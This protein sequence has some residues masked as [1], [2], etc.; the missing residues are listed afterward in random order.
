MLEFKPHLDQTM[1]RMEAFWEH[2]VLDRPVAQFTVDKPAGERVPLP[3]ANHATSAERWLDV[4]YQSRL[5][6]AELSNRL[7]PGDSLPV[8]FPNL[9]PEILAAFYGC[10]LHFGDYGTSWTEPINDGTGIEEITL[11]W[12][13]PYFNKLVELTDAML[14][15]G[16]GKYIVGM[17]DWHPG[18]D[19]VAAL[20]NPQ[21][22]ASDLIENP[23]KV[24][25]LLKHLQPDYFKVYNYWYEKLSVSGQPITSW[26]NLASYSKYYIPS[27]DFAAMI[28]L[29]MFQ[30]F[31]LEGIIAECRFL[32]RSIYHLDGPGALRHL[33]SILTIRELD[34]LQW[35]PGAGRE[36]YSQWIPIYQKIQ[37]AG[38]SIIVYCKVDDLNL[39]METLSPCGL[40]LSIEDITD[41]ETGENILSNLEKWTQNQGWEGKS[42]KSGY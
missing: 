33:D 4:D 8:A 26:L 31:F 10:P 1:K 28:S 21:T 27:N 18:G 6:D 41:L 2:S 7:Y 9:G 32:D 25:A 11:D 3:E 15:L 36:G 12:E 24:R 17:P 37:A 34:A 30:E 14:E 39:V 16:R 38:K 29:N 35:V 22:L 5:A 13:H 40:A 19:L 42:A 20:R 23:E